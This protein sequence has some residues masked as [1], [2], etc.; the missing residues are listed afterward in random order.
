MRQNSQKVVS[1]KHLPVIT[2]EEN[3]FLFPFWLSGLYLL[4]MTTEASICVCMK[5]DDRLR[6]RLERVNDF[7]SS[8]CFRWCGTHNERAEIIAKQLPR[9]ADSKQKEGRHKEETNISQPHRYEFIYDVQSGY[10][11]FFLQR[12][13]FSSEWNE[14]RR[15]PRE[16]CFLSCFY[17]GIFVFRFCLPYLPNRKLPCPETTAT[18]LRNSRLPDKNNNNKAT[19]SR[20]CTKTTRRLISKPRNCVKDS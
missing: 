16:A 1:T 4:S 18:S 14:F 20:G 10:L 13:S 12:G 17:G 3:F 11:I 6:L 8:I 7:I 19:K 15:I 2:S 9:S 5:T